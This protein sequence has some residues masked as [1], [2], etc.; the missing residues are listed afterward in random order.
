MRALHGAK[1][2]EIRS[3]IH[4]DHV[5]AREGVP[6]AVVPGPEHAEPQ[7]IATQGRVV[8]E[9]VVRERVDRSRRAETVPESPAP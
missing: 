3:R 8:E 4:E 6:G 5:A 2:V 7:G 9:Q 1:R